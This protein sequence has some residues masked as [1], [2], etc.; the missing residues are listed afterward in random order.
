MCV[1]VNLM[2]V[3]EEEL[4][5]VLITSSTIS[6]AEHPSWM[7]NICLYNFVTEVSVIRMKSYIAQIVSVH[8]T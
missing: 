8:L 4:M 6:S 1:H 5:I 7:Y 2:F 3:I